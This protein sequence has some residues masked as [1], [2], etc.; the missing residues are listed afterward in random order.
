MS[1]QS[2]KKQSQQTFI[3]EPILT[4]SGLMDGTDDFLDTDGLEDLPIDWFKGEP[5]QLVA[6]STVLDLTDL[7]ESVVD[8]EVSDRESDLDTL[9]TVAVTGESQ[10]SSLTV[11]P[12]ESGVFTVGERGEVG[13]DF[14]FDGGGYQGEL[15][16]FSL[17]GME[18]FEPGSEAFIQEAASRALS[19]SPLGHVVISDS[20]EG[21]MFSGVLGEADRNFGDYQG[22]KTFEM[23]PGD[24][25]GF[26]LVPNGTVQQVF[27]NPT[28]GGA[29]RPLFS[30]ATANPEDGFHVGQIADVTG[31]KHTFV[32]EDLRVDGW[33][34]KDYNDVIFQVTGATGEAAQL[35][36]LIAPSHDWRDSELG[37]ELVDYV[38]PSE[39]IRSHRDG[40]MVEVG[41]DL[42]S[43]QT[44]Y[45]AYLEEQANPSDFQTS[46]PLLQVYDGGVV[47]D[48]IAA[49]DPNTLLAD[50]NA[51]GLQNGSSFGSVVSGVLP[52]ES[53][54][55]MADLESLRF[56]RPAYQPLT[57]VGLITSQGDVA[58][59]ADDARSVFDVDGTAVT[60]GVLSDSF[61][62]L[63]GTVDDIASGDL[64][65]GINVLE[66][67][68]GKDEGRAMLQLIHDVAPGADLAFHTANLGIAN[69]ANGIV[70]L[71]DAGADVIVDDIAY[72]NAPM[73]Q[74]GHIAQAVDTVVGNGVSYFS[75]AG[76]MA[77]DSYES[78]FRDSGLTF[79]ANDF[80]SA[81]NAPIFFGGK[82]H[83][84]DPGS[85]V[86]IFQS[87]SLDPGQSFRTSFQWDEPFFSVSGGA[88]VTNEMDIYILNENDEIVGGKADSNFGGDAVDV[89]GFTNTTGASANYKFM[90][91][92]DTSFGGTSPGLMKYV[93]F[94][95]V[96]TINEF[97]TNSS[98]IFGHANAKG[99]I[100]VGAAGYDQTPEFGITPPK[101]EDFSSYGSTPVLF[102]PN[103]N[104]L[105]TPEIRQNPD[106]VAPDGTS[107]TVPGF[108]SFFGTS[109]AAPHAAAVAA[110]MLD[111][112]PGTSPDTIAQVL[113]DTA[114]DMDDPNTPGFDVDFDNA[115]GHGFIDATL[116]IQALV[117]PTV[118]INA[119][120]EEA[121]EEP[122]D[123]GQF[124]VTRTGKTDS[125]LT[126]NYT[127]TGTA[128]NGTDY[129][130]LSGSVTIP[131]G[132]SSFRI[133]LIP[134]DDIAVEGNETVELTLTP[135]LT[136]KIDPNGGDA[137]VTIADNDRPAVTISTTDPNAAEAGLD[138]GEFTIT[139]NSDIGDL[140]VNYTVTGSATNGTDYNLLSGSVTI[141]NGS[142][143]ATIPIIPIDDTTVEGDE[144]VVVNLQTNPNYSVG[145]TK[146]A[147]VTIADNDSSPPTCSPSSPYEPNNTLANA[148]NLGTLSGTPIS[149]SDCISSSDT[150]DYYRF[151][152][153]QAQIRLTV[154]NLSPGTQLG[155]DVV[156][157]KGGSTQ[158]SSFTISSGSPQTLNISKTSAIGGNN[159][160]RVYQI[161]GNSN[162]KFDI[163]N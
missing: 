69:F 102:D 4:R 1:R 101:L 5:G 50:L 64:P 10:E 21:A 156:S 32:M 70:E 127:I 108:E 29:V 140:T 162:Y 63:G 114:I 51:L 115:T 135:N 66:D 131:A 163:S 139:R 46:N 88:G 57:N 109:A 28:I 82:A 93:L 20:T 84:F 35:D 30:L 119:T 90:I 26:M 142:T 121:S 113:Q 105:A 72:L 106:I 120:D 151:N 52:I 44:E 8:Q 42:A 107:T 43:L 47:I 24:E 2:S 111:A 122:G 74:D 11:S 80:T 16:V 77:R 15:A 75:S 144:T 138:K 110:L 128:T 155:V 103:G 96:P 141:P 31:D 123:S 143:K 134:I 27:D 100:A 36:D 137:T 54:D 124:T 85:G 87:F 112:A 136:Y 22:V 104:R 3:L 58:M 150:N 37:Q 132:L 99:A 94:N 38:T 67:S 33:T 129:K 149:I 118:S 41:S 71:A 154:N 45:Q 133:P 6:D 117:A 68:S 145:T 14:L 49:D 12:F 65:A 152:S 159:H 78:P 62:A 25:F 39:P 17:E 23:R 9:N 18:E 61:N 146:S 130:S 60:V 40:L 81:P 98:T 148:Y 13:V 91:V 116:A 83:D 97:A 73:F 158:K 76:N 157:V 160:I 59:N 153:N 95:D 147:T 79:S 34:D 86:D 92:H 125:P 89:F 161:S 56:A 48:A 7:P 55:E 53:I 126:L 19:D